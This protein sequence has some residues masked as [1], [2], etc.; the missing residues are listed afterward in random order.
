MKIWK[1]YKFIDFAHINP[2]E[3]LAKGTLAKK[4]PMEAVEPFTKRISNFEE[5]AYKG[6][7]KFRNNDTIMARITP[8]LENGKTAFVDI[9]E[10]NEIGYGSTEFV[11]FREKKDI[12]DAQYIYYFS[13]S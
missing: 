8:S 1:E 11:V 6:G 13:I 9:L 4:V 7:V 2:R 10:E 3:S 5:K 12:S